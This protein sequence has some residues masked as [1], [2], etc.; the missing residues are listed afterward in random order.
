MLKLFNSATKSKDVFEPLNPKRVTMYVCGPTVYDYAHIGNA[1]PAVIFD[2]LN[3]L[4]R[5]LYGDNSVIY[6]RNITDIDDKII[7][8]AKEEGVGSEVISDRYTKAYREDMASLG[9]LAP[10]IEPMAT[11]FIPA[12]ITQ[13]KAII[14]N[15]H[16]YVSEGHVLFDI[17]SFPDHGLLSG[18]QNPDD[19]ESR[20]AETSYKRDPRDFVLWK[21][22]KLNEP[23]WP[24]PWGYGR[25]G[26][27]IECSAMIARTLGLPIDI[28][29]GGIDLLFPHHE[30]ERSQGLCAQ[31]TCGH[32]HEYAKYW[33]HN[34][35]LTVNQD[36][37]GK[38]VGNA[39]TV[40]ELMEERPYDYCGEIIRAALLSAHH[41]TLLDWNPLLLIDTKNRLDGLYGTLLKFKHIEAT[42]DQP[43]KPFIESMMNDM[44]LPSALAELSLLATRLETEGDKEVT[45]GQLLASAKILGLLQQDPFEW[46]KRGVPAKR[47]EYYDLLIQDRNKAR[48]EKDW[49]LA[50]EIRNT[51]GCY[52][53]GV[54]DTPS[55]TDWRIIS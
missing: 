4:L 22:S 48:L 17:A 24:S 35:F 12:M 10:T 23:S 53:I 31:G 1:R 55:G 15:G 45:K 29:G 7:A 26:W 44:N 32:N 9:V 54:L 46:F 47:R 40:R 30:N 16:A 18:N 25:P 3:R 50:D 2:V 6:V 11:D 51:L 36:R 42:G 34:A 39:L 20:L 13:I 49:A 5:H 38:S 21:P 28:H 19:A 52:G 14:A 41:A 43:S 27:H 33:V 8:K 37:M